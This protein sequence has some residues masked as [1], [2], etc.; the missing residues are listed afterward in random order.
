M[1]TIYTAL[2]F[3]IAGAHSQVRVRT[4]DSKKLT[5]CDLIFRILKK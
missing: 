3:E 2:V 1:V 5:K 4:I